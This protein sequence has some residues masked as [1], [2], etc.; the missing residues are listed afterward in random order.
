VLTTCITPFCDYSHIFVTED[1]EYLP[2]VS[3]IP[4]QHLNS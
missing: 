2:S 4:N 3:I 1:P